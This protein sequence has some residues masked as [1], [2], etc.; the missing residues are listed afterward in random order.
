VSDK[1]LLRVLTIFD[2]S[3]PA[4]QLIKVL[5]NAGEIV[6]D[7]RVEDDEDMEK[8][9]SENPFDIILAKQ[10]LPMFSAQQA[11]E[12]LQKSGHDIPLV[13]ITD[14]DDSKDTLADLKAGARDTV[15]P[16]Q[17]ERLLHI[18]KREVAD[19]KNRKGV[20]RAEQM[21][22]DSEKRARSLIDSSRDAI[23]YVHDGMHIYANQAYLEMFGYE[24][25]DD[26][27]GMPILDMVGSKDHGTLKDFL[28]N[29]AKGLSKDDSLDIE[30]KHTDGHT[31]ET[32]MEFSPA[33]MEGET[34]TQI[35][36]RDRSNSK[37]LE[38]QLNVLSKQDL[39]TGLFNRSY[40]LDKVDKLITQAVEGKTK[41]AV[42]FIE[43]DKFDDIRNSIG[44]ASADQFIANIA[45]LLKEKLDKHGLVARFEGPVFTLLLNNVDIKQAE[46]AAA[47]IVKL[48]GEHT[49]TIAGK[50]IDATTS[51]GLTPVNETVSNLQDCITR[52]EKGCETAKN[53][54]GNQYNIFNPAMEDLAD[55]EKVSVWSHR[56]KEALRNNQFKL[57]YQPIVS[58]H[59]IAGGHYEVT[60]RMLD[61][62]GEEIPAKEFI[63]AADQ[64]DLTRF[65][66]RW[67]IANCLAAYQAQIAKGQ[68]TRFF[69]KLSQ[70]TLTDADFLTWVSE[71]I[72]SFKLDA[73][74]L[75]FEIDESIALNHLAQSKVMIQGLKQLKCR[76]AL[77]NFGREQNTFQAMQELPV[78]FIKLH[79]DLVKNLPQSEENQEAM[80]DIADHARD[81]N[82]Q[83]I[84]AFVE[85][86][87]SLAVLWQCS[88]DFIQGHFLQEPSPKLDFDFD[89]AF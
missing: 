23:S 2:E 4:E 56:I 7:I 60:V 69:L 10:M 78:D 84:A 31:F 88:V 46:Q 55:N 34:C 83:S 86:A 48:I 29:Y 87:N 47:G 25:Q 77:E 11:L 41:G 36:I 32:A 61:D 85:D 43:I 52:A 18:V 17:P 40:F 15:S 64:A 24:S 59:G 51:V 81:A 66:D 42:L 19:L 21:L 45:G 75:I 76:T 80:K 1:D 8:A 35:I 6:R 54:G 62:A 5:R 89:S 71:L 73:S 13:V 12:L 16:N 44:I 14:L 28:R 72:K 53:D 67:I 79:A 38:Q 49:A 9:I 39:L 37:E 33:S 22:R 82:M 70:N 68:D 27:E 58:L 30:A 3:E 50:V 65:V 63:V 20:R 57:L 74:G 26:V